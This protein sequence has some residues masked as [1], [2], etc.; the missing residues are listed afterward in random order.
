M[1]AAPPD[2]VLTVRLA[3]AAD[4]LALGRLAGR[5]SAR[6]PTGD[7]LLAR[8]TAR[9]G[10]P[11]RPTA[12][13][14]SPT[15]SGPPP[16][17]SSCCACAAPSYAGGDPAVRGRHAWRARSRCA[18]GLPDARRP[19]HA[20]PVLAG[21]RRALPEGFAPA[22]HEA[23]AE[24]HL[25]L[26]FPG[27]PCARRSGC[28]R[29]ARQRTRGRWTRRTCAPWRPYRTWVAVLLRAVLEDET[30]EIAARRA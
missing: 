8:S 1:S 20:A 14:S 25:H 15:P 6:V 12:R 22:A 30:G 17:S 2:E 19:L 16:S 18:P 10:R 29:W 4:H 11:S 21:R 7:V 13:P 26:A 28:G 27:S 9:C 24:G 3:E 23:A 5:D